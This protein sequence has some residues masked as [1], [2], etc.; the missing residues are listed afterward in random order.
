MC[1]RFEADWDAQAFGLISRPLRDVA[2]QRYRA[3]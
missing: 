2:I 1:S 3:T